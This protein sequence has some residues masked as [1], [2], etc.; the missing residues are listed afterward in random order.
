M[1]RDTI[2][3][4]LSLPLYWSKLKL[5][6]RWCYEQGWEVD[7]TQ[8]GMK[9]CKRIDWPVGEDPHQVVSW[10]YF[11][12]FWKRHYCYIVIRRPTADICDDCYVFYNQVKF[13]TDKAPKSP[14]V[15]IDSTDDEEGDNEE[16]DDD[17]DSNVVVKLDWKSETTIQE[18]DDLETMIEK[19]NNHVQQA[20]DMRMLLC[21]KARLSLDWYTSIQDEATISDERWMNAIDCIVGDYC[22]TLPYHIWEN[23]NQAKLTTSLH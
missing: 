8:K 4:A 12:S 10:P 17:V 19:A 14:F 13:K 9:L 1:T 5:F 2:K 21:G 23:T 22:R 18:G 7:A 16:D 3:D 11:F 15:E 6:C 20:K